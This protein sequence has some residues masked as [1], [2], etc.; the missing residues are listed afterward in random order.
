MVL[1]TEAVSM[2]K[3][4]KSHLARG[5]ASDNILTDKLIR[6]FLVVTKNAIVILIYFIIILKT[7]D[8]F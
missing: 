5:Y 3:K 7:D 6:Y 8:N 1:V 4:K 2:I